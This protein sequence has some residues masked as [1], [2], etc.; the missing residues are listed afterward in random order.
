MKESNCKVGIPAMDTLLRGLGK[1][2]NIL[3]KG[4]AAVLI[5]FVAGMTLV[6]FLQVV[7]R[8]VLVRPLYWSEELARYM[9]VWL[10]MFGAALGLQKQGHF[11][12][13]VF[14][15]MLSDRWRK[16]AGLLIHLLM[17]ALILVILVQGILLVQKTALQDSPA[18]GIPMSWAYACLPVGAALMAIH[19]LVI[20]L[21]D[22]TKS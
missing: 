17:G 7:Y 20:F 19:L 13:D 18:M 3:A 1:F 15:K 8:Y 10:S 12:L 2:D 16:R 22:T 21:K 6:V 11:G 9:F 4:E 5:I 14:Y